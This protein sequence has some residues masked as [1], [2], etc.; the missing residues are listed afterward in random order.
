M[1]CCKCN[2]RGLVRSGSEGENVVQNCKPG[3]LRG[4]S[5]PDQI[6]NNANKFSTAAQDDKKKVKIMYFVI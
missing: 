4:E 6:I 1:T 3:Q 2:K 5:G